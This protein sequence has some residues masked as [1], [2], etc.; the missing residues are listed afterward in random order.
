ML[1]EK[2]LGQFSCKMVGLWIS[3]KN[4][5]QIEIWS[6]PSMKRKYWIFFMLWIFGILIYCGN[7]SRLKLITKASS[8]FCN[9][10]FHPRSNKNGLTRSLAMIMRSFIRREN[11]MWSPMLFP[12]NMKKKG[13]SFPHPLLY[14]LGFELLTR[15]GCKTPKYLS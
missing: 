4:K 13:P 9:K 14:L 7:I 8:I 1:L 5:F 12:E 15:N 10:E 6:K 3:P 2:E 11:K